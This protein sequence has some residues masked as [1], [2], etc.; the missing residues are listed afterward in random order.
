MTVF[1]LSATAGVILAVVIVVFIVVFIKISNKKKKERGEELANPSRD[2]TEMD[3]RQ[4]KVKDIV[5]ISG[6]GDEFDD[7]DFEIEKKNRYESGGEEWFELLGVYKSRQV[8]IE[9]EEDDALEITATSPDRKIKLSSLN[10][11]EEDLGQMDGR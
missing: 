3:I 2:F 5:S 4:A 1:A 10:V 7:V 9:W 6:Y 8:W 11:T